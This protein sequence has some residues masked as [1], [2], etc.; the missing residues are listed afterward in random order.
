MASSAWRVHRFGEI[1][2]R[3]TRKNKADEDLPVLSCTKDGIRFQLDHFNKQVASTDLSGYLV[4]EDGEVVISGLNLWLGGVDVQKIA[5]RGLVSPAYKVFRQRREAACP[6]FMRYYL[7]SEIMMR[8][9]DLVSAQGASIVRRNVNFDELLLTE[10]R[11]PP[12]PEQRKIAAILGSVDEAIRATQTVIEQTRTVKQGLLQEL[13]TR[14][15]GHTRLRLTE[16]GE[17]PEKWEVR[18]VTN[19]C[20]EIFLGLTSKVDYV[21]ENGVP[22]IRA[23]DISTG[24]LSFT[25]ARCISH[26]QHA[27]LTRYRKP[28]RGDVL[29]TK[30]GTLGICALVDTDQD[31]SIYE[32]IIDLQPRAEILDS[33]FLLWLM[34][35]GE[36]QYRLLGERVGSTVGHLN[37]LD[38]RRL[39]IPVPPIDEQR[40]IA[41]ILSSIDEAESNSFAQLKR[42]QM[43]RTGLIQDLLTG[44]VRVNAD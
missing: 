35:S 23:K 37:L 29:I 3:V 33:T 12:L 21:H 31:F 25:E 36:T 5:P 6:D 17:L 15:I 42:H 19:C 24:T 7:R 13:L 41:A 22:L 4:V 43:L 27:Q 38:F 34:R 44:Q 32:S 30:S 9:Y 1:Y 26:E 8:V 40:E 10:L 18:G 16:I 39:Q 2:E 28:K 20:D 14:G 11:L